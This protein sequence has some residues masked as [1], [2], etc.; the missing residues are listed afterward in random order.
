MVGKGESS[1][2]KRRWVEITRNSLRYYK[3]N[4]ILNMLDRKKRGAAT[5]ID[6]RVAMLSMDKDYKHSFA[7]VSPHLLD[8]ETNPQGRLH[9]R[10]V[11]DEE[12]NKW[13]SV[14]RNLSHGIHAV[15]V[16]N[17]MA[18]FLNEQVEGLN[19]LS[20]TGEFPVLCS[21]TGR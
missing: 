14:L 18:I 8:A 1:L 19:S 2:W 21:S 6:L 9:F 12:L 15:Y 10:C 5:V 7:L 11:D 13:V 4:K 17:E 20:N 3:R 16:V